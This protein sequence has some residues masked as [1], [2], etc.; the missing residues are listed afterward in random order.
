MSVAVSRTRTSS[1]VNGSTRPT[2]A[3]KDVLNPATGETIAEVPARHAESDVDRAVEAAKRRFR[4]WLDTTP[5]ER[6]EMLLEARRPARRATPR[7]SRQLESANVGK[8]LGMR[9]RRD[10]RLRADNIRFFAGAARCIEGQA[11]GEYMRGLHLD[12]PARAARRRRP[13]RALELPADDG[14]VEVRAG[15]RGRERRSSSRPSTR[16]CPR[17]ARA[18]RARVLPAGRPQRDHRRRR[19]RRRRARPPPRRAPR[20]ADRRRRHRQGDRAGRRRTRS[21]A[22]TSSSAARRRSSSSTTPTRPR[23]PRRQARRLLEL[24]PGLHGGLAGPRGPEDLRRAARGA[25]AR[26][27]VAEGRRPGRRRRRSR[28]GP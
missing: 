3:T 20:L 16:R 17:S 15:A 6:S 2:D 28:W 13:D 5:G 10:A 14:G 23:S 4:E 12:D 22:S 18:V 9:A 27:R 24:R 7:S 11:T 26:R 25:R 8:P 21:S 1:A 19:A